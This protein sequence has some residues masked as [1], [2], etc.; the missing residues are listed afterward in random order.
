[1]ASCRGLCRARLDDALL[2]QANT[3]A[4][5]ILEEMEEMHGDG[6]GRRIRVIAEMR[7]ARQHGMRS[8]GETLLRPQ[9]PVRPR[10]FERQRHKAAAAGSRTS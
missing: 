6:P 8:C 7:P 5:L 3:A 9:A 4:A 10:E 2:S 1:M